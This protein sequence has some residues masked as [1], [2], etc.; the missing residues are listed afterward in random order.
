MRKF[1]CVFFVFLW[2]ES[3][4]TL[5]QDWTNTCVLEPCKNDASEREERKSPNPGKRSAKR[6]VRV[7]AANCDCVTCI[8]KLRTL[9][10]TLVLVEVSIFS[11]FFC[12]GEGKGSPRGQ[13]RS[14]FRFLLKI[15]GGGGGLPGEEGGG[16]ARGR[17]GVC[18][19]LGGGG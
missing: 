18:G 3:A 13:E 2:S 9:M 1:L 10:R 16:G 12:S 17:E 4:T 14:G 5:R 8:S 7:Y 19:E 11:I 15:P 6:S